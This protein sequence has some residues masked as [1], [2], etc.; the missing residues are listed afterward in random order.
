MYVILPFSFNLG[1]GYERHVWFYKKANFNK[2]NDLIK[3]TNWNFLSYG[4][5][6]DSC[7][8]FTNKL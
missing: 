7:L 3:N 1:K 6:N 2:L 4:D 8:A 5:L